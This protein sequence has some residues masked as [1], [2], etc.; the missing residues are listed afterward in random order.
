MDAPEGVDFYV[1]GAQIK[2]ID[3]KLQGLNSNAVI[4]LQKPAGRDTAFGGEQTL[5]APTLY[6]AM[7]SSKLKIVDAK[8]P[9]N[10]KVHPKNMAWTFIY[11]DEG[12]RFDNIQLCYGE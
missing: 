9:T 4:G 7:D 5:K 8:V 12:T 11:Q 1:I 10:K 6:L 2:K 3:Q